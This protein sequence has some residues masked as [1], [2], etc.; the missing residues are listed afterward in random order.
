MADAGVVDGFVAPPFAPRFPWA[1]GDLQTVR[2]SAMRF[3]APSLRRWPGERLRLPMADGSG[4]RLAA[5]L[6]RP[7]HDRGRPLAIL[8]HGLTGCEDSIYVRASARQLLED[9]YPVLRLNL[10]GAGPSGPLCTQR[11]HAG[12]SEDLRRTLAA[13]DPEVV[14]NGLLAVGYSLG[15]NMLLKYLGEEGAAAPFAAAVTVSAPLDLAAT[16]HRFHAPR[17]R[18]YLGYMMRRIKEETLRPGA[19]LD[20]TMREAVARSRTVVEFDEVCV[21]PTNGFAGAEDYYARCMALRFLGGVRVPTLVVH[22]QDDPWI[23]VDAYRGFDWRSNPALT[24]LLPR[25]G[26]HVGFHGFGSRTPW[27]DRAAALFLKRVLR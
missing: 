8:I 6:H 11:Y 14:A 4:D 26:G 20:P 3:A 24:L 25:A 9:G 18:V 10:R 16:A 15:A 27:H 23:P 12:R 19:A 17:N 7:E 21:A 5:M 1:T 22:A 13:L 2:N